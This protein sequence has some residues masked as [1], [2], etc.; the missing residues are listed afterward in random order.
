MPSKPLS[1]LLL[2]TPQSLT[3]PLYIATAGQAVLGRLYGLAATPLLLLCVLSRAPVLERLPHRGLT[4][5]VAEN[6]LD[7][8]TTALGEEDLEANNLVVT[9][10]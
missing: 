8:K 4:A 1:L 5:R 10:F 2:L 7:A 3:R 9:K 6:I